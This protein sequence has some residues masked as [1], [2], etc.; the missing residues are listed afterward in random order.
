ML[1]NNI[2]LT[3]SVQWYKSKKGFDLVPCSGWNDKTAS[4][5]Q[6]EVVVYNTEIKN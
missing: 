3:I 4:F 6:T 5:N 1:Y 2:T